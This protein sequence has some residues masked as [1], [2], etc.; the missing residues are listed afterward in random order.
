MHYNELEDKLVQKQL[1]ISRWTDTLS[2]IALDI[3]N[4]LIEW[5]C[6]ITIWKL[7]HHQNELIWELQDLFK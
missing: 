3:H 2:R 7:L 4:L 1:L 6:Y 5:W